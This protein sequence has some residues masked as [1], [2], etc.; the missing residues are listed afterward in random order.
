MEE[1]IY[2]SGQ[3]RVTGQ[4]IAVYNSQESS[5]LMM[6]IKKPESKMYIAL[7]VNEG[8]TAFYIKRENSVEPEL[9]C[10]K[11]GPEVGFDPNRK[12]PYW[13]SYDRDKLAIKYGKGHCMDET[14]ILEYS[15]LDNIPLSEERNVKMKMCEFFDHCLKREI[16]IRKITEME[17]FEGVTSDQE[18]SS[19][20]GT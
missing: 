11:S 8:H 7:Q 18:D 12:I 2:A 16:Q 17:E 14:V 15:F 1:R 10:E 4:G 9:L 3:F 19:V 5:P 20:N 13:L 6:T